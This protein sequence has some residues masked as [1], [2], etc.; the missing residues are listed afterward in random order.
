MFKYF[1]IF[2]LIFIIFI[3]LLSLIIYIAQLFY[4]ITETQNK[5]WYQSTGFSIF[6]NI[7][8]LVLGIVMLRFYVSGMFD[9][10]SVIILGTILIALP[11]CFFVYFKQRNKNVKL[12]Q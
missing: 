3:S 1:I 5:S 4:K 6:R 11:E 8:S 2:Y 9:E 7:Y 12:T 10:W